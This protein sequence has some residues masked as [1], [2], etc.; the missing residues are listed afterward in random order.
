MTLHEMGNK[1]QIFYTSFN[2][3]TLEVQEEALDVMGA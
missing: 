2:N 3:R 1:N